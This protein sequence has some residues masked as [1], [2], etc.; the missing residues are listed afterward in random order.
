MDEK[1]LQK[2]EYF[3][4]LDR[5]RDA[6][7][8]TTGKERCLELR[9]SES[10]FEIRR[11]QKETEE[12]FSYLVM[13]NKPPFG[14]MKDIR[15]ALSRT[16]IDGVL[17]MSELLDIA[18]TIHVVQKMKAYGQREKD[19]T[20]YECLDPIFNG[21]APISG[22]EKEITRCIL[23]EE[24]MSDNASA[25]LSSIRKEIHITQ[26]RVR[27]QLQCMIHS[28]TYKT[29]LQDAVITMRNGRYCVP[30]KAEHRGS[31]K[32]MVH[33]QSGSGS[34]LFIEPMAV[35]QLNN[36]STELYNEEQ[37][38]IHRILQDLSRL[39]GQHQEELA[40]DYELL[41]Q[42]DFIFAKGKLAVEMNAVKPVF[43]EEGYIRL[44]N[45]RH[46]LLDDKKVV[47][48]SVWLGRDFTSLV[49]TG[50][51]TGGKTVTLKTLG[52]L[53][54]MGQAG[55]HI[56]TSDKPSLAVLDA[57]FAD[58]G[59]EQSIEQSLST[60]SSHMVN[61]VE[62]LQNV[63]DRSLVLFDELGAGT[64]PVEGA[65]LANA[66]LEN[67]RKRR[68]LTAA[69][70]HYSELKVYALSTE[71]VENASCEFDVETLQPTY[72]LLIGVPGKS[73]AFAISKRLGLPDGIIRAAR[74]LLE[75]NDVKFEE[76][77]TDLELRRRQV[78]AEQD[79]I[80][81]LRIELADLKRQASQAKQK[82]EEQKASILK[83]AN[84]SA[85]DILRKA[86]AEADESIQA[87]NRMIR[88][89][90][91]IDMRSLEEQR[92]KLREKV[93]QMDQKLAEPIQTPVQRVDRKKIKPGVK[94]KLSTFDQECIV[95]SEPDAK[96][97]LQVQAGIM[98]MQ[99]KLTDI[100]RIIGEDAQ[101][102]AQGR[103]RERSQSA[104]SFGKAQTIG[105]EVDLRG[106]TSDEALAVVDKYLDDAYLAGVPKVT[107]IHGKGT[108][109]LRQAVHQYLKR[110]AHV[111]AYRLG[112][113]GEGEA[114]V[115]IVEIKQH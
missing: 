25:K 77:I 53:S 49:I 114:G 88:E 7:D 108:G 82:L 21:L 20:Y 38:E 37:R 16:K 47:P 5:L 2:L 11:W 92:T 57:V 107:I 68:I 74:E 56:P 17:T 109:A 81:S 70:T 66:I 44:P 32:G 55:L 71:G 23:S 112:A 27:S 94:I 35:V 87:M 39:V 102:K 43:N 34:T 6:A 91:Q 59:D 72:R 24:E 80:R 111:A 40:A 115:T 98:K 93:T 61:I 101:G 51:N 99:V 73:N 42:L 75:S 50:P 100:A 1:S 19:T 28:N 48:I 3:K 65:A 90:Q 29:M 63:T 8:S 36:R 86:K 12:A 106:M 46:P 96:G 76:M 78:E 84:E 67:L 10:I 13:K 83:K 15:M 62:I 69:T 33:D 22:V 26:E 89:G 14:G 31:I 64:D 4:I 104:G 30:V 85:R 58:I 113:F 52:L 45:A 60:F 105:L 41:V 18:D 97:N 110:N 95:L 103:K 79:Q 9:P 54:I